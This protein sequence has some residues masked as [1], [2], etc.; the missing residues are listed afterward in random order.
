MKFSKITEQILEKAGWYKGRSIDICEYLCCYKESN[1]KES[2]KFTSKCLSLFSEL[3]NSY[4]DIHRNNETLNSY[5][6]F[7]LLHNTYYCGTINKTNKYI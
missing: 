4:T 2:T 5:N 3:G 7:V 6:G 1:I